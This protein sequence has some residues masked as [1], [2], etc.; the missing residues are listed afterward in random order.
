MR[1]RNSL[2]AL[3]LFVVACGGSTAASVPPKLDLPIPPV[4]TAATAAMP[5]HPVGVRPSPPDAAPL[6]EVP[7][8]KLDVTAAIQAVVDAKDRS[9]EDRKLDAGR[10]PAQFLAFVRAMPGM[11]VAEIGAAGGYTTELLARA[12]GPKGKVYAENSA[13]LLKFADKPWTER[14]KKKE[15]KNVVRLDR[16][17]DDPFPADVKN[18]DVVVINMLYHDTVNWKIDT[19]K[20]NKAVLAV[21]KPGGAYIVV[22]HSSRPGR[23]KTETE[24]LHR[25][26]ERVVRED[27]GRAGFKLLEDADFFRN[28]ADTRDWS[29]SPM[30]AGEKRG[31]SDRFALR[32]IK[33]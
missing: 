5:V 1:S 29:A 7:H 21:L 2:G 19:D 17:M 8:A 31:T 24:S 12:V 15:M 10:H 9:D 30:A 27:L 23:G 4:E 22:D 33:P 18:V 20:M 14:L 16:E 3:L 28:G 25:I 11:T 32:F 13:K 6:P 26:D